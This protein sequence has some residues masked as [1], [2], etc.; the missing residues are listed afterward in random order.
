MTLY[1]ETKPNNND[2]LGCLHYGLC[3]CLAG[4]TPNTWG[5]CNHKKCS[6]EEMMSYLRKELKKR[7]Y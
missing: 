7:G 2:C 3:E 6:Q 5:Q 4:Y 1:G